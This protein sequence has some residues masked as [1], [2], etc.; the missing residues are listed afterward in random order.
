M[1]GIFGLVPFDGNWKYFV[2]KALLAVA[3]RGKDSY[4]VTVLW[5]YNEVYT[6]KA[7]NIKEL[8]T[9]L[10]KCSSSNSN[11]D[12][13]LAIIGVAR[14][15]PLQEVLSDNMKN[16]PPFLYN[17]FSIVHN[18]IVSNDKELKTKYGMILES[19][20][21]TEVLLR[22]LIRENK[23]RYLGITEIEGSASLIMIDHSNGAIWWYRDF[24]PLYFAKYKNNL[25]IISTENMA[26]QV[27]DK[28][29]NSLDIVVRELE[30][31]Y[32]GVISCD[33]TKRLEKI[34]QLPFKFKTKKVHYMTKSNPIKC[35]AVCSG[36]IDSTTSAA[37]F[38]EQGCDVLF[39]F[40]DYGQK[41]RDA[42]LNAIKQIAIHYNMPFEVIDLKWLGDL[43]G[44]A[45]TDKNIEIPN[46]IESCET[47]RC[48]TPARNL[49]ML[50]IAA[51]YADRHGYGYITFG[52]NL[53]ENS[54]P[55]PDNESEFVKK[56]NS[57]LL[58]GCLNE[59]EIITPFSHKMKED[60]VK[61]GTEHKVPY[62]L[63]HSC[64]L[65]VWK[66]NNFWMCGKC[67]CCYSSAMAFKKAGI[68]DI[69]LNKY[70]ELGP[71]IIKDFKRYDKK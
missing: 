17:N 8:T 64:D 62:Q 19:E 9:T 13:P 40:F 38:I 20:N 12:Y 46:G 29:Y 42:E 55:Y 53:Q 24:K 60:I 3:D 69:R 5:D 33:S 18:G 36:G 49:V 56:M 32:Y 52:A 45:L 4:G 41:A 37:W 2:K 65:A 34:G 7:K 25:L 11:R 51:A 44:S 21:D 16:N 23:L 59:V 67:G 28:Q 35:I 43:G 27:F 26:Y 1:C 10:K 63:T 57:A 50:S 22:T 39:M 48:W 14:A 71:D 47:N 30:P 54:S 58:Y 31:Y 6:F 61:W 15:Q 70:I 66:S 68:K